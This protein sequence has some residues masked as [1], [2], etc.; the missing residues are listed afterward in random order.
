MS[1]YS[2]SER[3]THAEGISVMTAY[4]PCSLAFSTLENGAIFGHF[5]LSAERRLVN[6][7]DGSKSRSVSC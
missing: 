1:G 7:S 2:K 5:N 6:E 4:S 3:M